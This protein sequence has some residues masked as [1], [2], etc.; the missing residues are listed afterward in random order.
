MTEDTKFPETI[1][2]SLY[3]D[4]AMIDKVPNPYKEWM[5]RCMEDF[6]EFPDTAHPLYAVYW[7]NDVQDWKKKWF[8][9]F[10]EES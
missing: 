5:K 6:P 2:D 1:M 7:N 10:E 9:Q 8:S 4:K 3:N